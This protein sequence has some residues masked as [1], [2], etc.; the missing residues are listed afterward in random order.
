MLSLLIYSL[1]V[2]MVGMALLFWL[3]R[4]RGDA[5]IVDVAWAGGIGLLAI[6]AAYCGEGWEP[7]RFLVGLMGSVWSIR[8]TVHLVIDRQIRAGREDGRYQMLRNKW[9]AK[10]QRRFFYF[11]QGQAMLVVLFGLPFVAVAA[12]ARVGWTAWDAAG[13]VVWTVAVAG[14]WIADRQLAAFRRQA[15]NQGRT[16]DLGLWRYSRHPN[17]F[18]EW[19]HWWAYVAMAG[20]SE[21]GWLAWVGPVLMWF[22]LSRVTGIP[23]T[24]KRALVTRGEDYRRYQRVTSSFIPWFP[25]RDYRE[26]D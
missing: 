10:A 20:G 15:A 6:A 16:C 13:L 23:Y 2:A 21:S 1:P 7:R 24:E 22:L 19:V 9:G 26:R 5:G 12:N 11:F 25:R 3:Q 17:Y 8:L 4:R 18:F 14:E